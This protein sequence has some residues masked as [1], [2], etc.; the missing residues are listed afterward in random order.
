MTRSIFSLCPGRHFAE[1]SVCRSTVVL[2]VKLTFLIKVFIAISSILAT[3]HIDMEVGEDNVPI[4][5]PIDYI[6]DFVRQA[7]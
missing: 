2:L 1:N 6:P 4:P 5:P 7:L 3:F